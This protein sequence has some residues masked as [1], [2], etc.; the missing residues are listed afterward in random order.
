MSTVIYD[1]DASNGSSVIV[2]GENEIN[3]TANHTP[4]TSNNLQIGAFGNGQNQF[5]GQIAEFIVYSQLLTTGADLQKI[6]SYLA[7]KY[8][9]T[10]SGNNDG[11]GTS[12]E[13]GE[14]DYLLSNGTAMWDADEVA[15][16]QNNVAG[17]ARDDNSCLNQK[18]SKSENADAIVSI[19]LDA[20]DN[21]L[22]ASNGANQS[23]FG[24]DL[25]A[26]VWGHDGA[27]LYDNQ[28]NIDYDP[29][30]VNSRL[31]REWRA[32]ETG[33]VGTV[34]IRFDVSNLLGPTG[35]GT[36]DE[37]QI[38]LLVDNDGDF[39]SGASEILQSFVVADDGFVSFKVNL[40]DGQYFTLGSSEFGALP[41]ELL[42]FDAK[43]KADYVELEWSTL[44]ETENGFFRLER[45]RD[46][47][48]FT[49]IGIIQGAG[50]TTDIQD[51]QH[52]DI[53][54]YN[55]LNYYRLVDI[56][57]GG[58]ENYSKIIAVEFTRA[59][60]IEQPYPN[61]VYSGQSLKVDLP[62]GSTIDQIRLFDGRG[63]YVPIRPKN[64]DGGLE[65]P[66]QTLKS[67]VYVLTLVISN[68]QY[69]FKI[70]VKD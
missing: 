9:I 12:F 23:T 7:L 69:S 39:T 68:K 63:V 25:S 17:I 35:V 13:A 5:R 2:N 1:E 33:T 10:L 44:S 60:A 14:G 4:N 43:A 26:L 27:D 18:Q 3:F 30:Q 31:N 59:V 54:P 61:P 56:S 21:G 22:E 48:N 55:G 50:T 46:A 70:I 47:R 37:S 11:D 15:G 51:Y 19:G 29:N 36:N 42:S 53:N 52:I 32:Q 64:S 65:I 8:G 66:T 58:E 34:T 38:V 62:S 20:N 6:Q 67:G 49:S 57:T 40:T 16:F 28:K 41:I 45:S 24:A